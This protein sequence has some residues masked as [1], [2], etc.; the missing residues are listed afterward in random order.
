[1][2]K[3]YLIVSIASLFLTAC[4]GNSTHRW[5]PPTKVTEQ[6]LSAPVVYEEIAIELSADTLFKFNKS[7]IND[8]LP[9]GK[10]ELDNVV[11]QLM[12]S[13]INVKQ[14]DITGH[15]DRLGSEQYNYKLGMQRAETIR[16]Y[17][18]NNGINNNINISS[19]GDSQPVTTSC[20]DVNS[21]AMLIACLQPDR[22]VTLNIIG[23]KDIQ[24][25]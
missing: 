24:I 7:S 9:N 19:Q 23:V 17:L 21:K 22:R 15:T 18:K 25:K 2:K 3:N 11:T 6:E 10:K 4:A 16:N 8:L 14:I 12:S 20:N 13:H 5:C 1:M